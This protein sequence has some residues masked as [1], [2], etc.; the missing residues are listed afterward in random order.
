MTGHAVCPECDEMLRGKCLIN[1]QVAIAA[2]VL[3]ERRSK[4][5]YMAILTCERSTICL[6]LMGR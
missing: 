3:I 4:T 2:S 5:F 1:L 6:G